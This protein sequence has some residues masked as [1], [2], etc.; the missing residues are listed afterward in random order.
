MKIAVPTRENQVD[1]HFG[2]CESYTVFT[3]ENNK[4]AQRET[5]ESPEGCGCKSDIAPL[6]AGMGV[7]VLLAGNMGMGALN[8][9]NAHGIQVIRGCTGDVDKIVDTFLKIGLSD[10]GKGCESHDGCHS[11]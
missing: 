11:H 5:M 4:I 6:L 10:S 8:I 3:I 9:L 7:K 1:D 2:H